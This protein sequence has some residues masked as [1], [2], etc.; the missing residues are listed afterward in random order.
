MEQIIC[1]KFRE[2][3]Y[4]QMGSDEDGWMCFS[5][6]LA[7]KGKATYMNLFF[8]HRSEIKGNVTPEKGERIEGGKE[9]FTVSP[10]RP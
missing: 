9:G 6:S 5:N 2:A 7:A 10:V 4:G 1:G 8:F 3:S